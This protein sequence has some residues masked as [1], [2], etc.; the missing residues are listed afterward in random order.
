MRRRRATSVVLAWLAGAAMLTGGVLVYAGHVLSNSDQF[1]T[2]ATA[3]LRDGAMRGVIARTLTSKLLSVEPD[4]VAVRPLVSGVA[5]LV[6]GSAPF[7]AIVEGAIYDVHR[8]VFVRGSDTFTIRLADLG[9]LADAQLRKFAPE[10][11]KRI[12]ESTS[13]VL[14]SVRGGE[15]GRVTDVGRSLN[16]ARAAGMWLLVAALLG[17]ILSI[18]LALKR[19]AA[20][21]RCGLVVLGAGLL[22]AVV[23]TVARALVLAQFTVGDARTAAGV[24][25]GA[26]LADFRFWALLAAGAGALVAAVAWLLGRRSAQS[27]PPEERS[28]TPGPPKRSP[29]SGPPERSPRRAVRAAAALGVTAL[30]I[31]G[32]FVL[33][34]A[35]HGEPRLEHPIVSCN[36]YAELCDRPVNQVVFPATHNSMGSSTE[37]GWFF[38]NQDGGIPEQLSAGSA[39]CLSTRTTGSRRRGEWRRC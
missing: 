36:G 20:L 30:V 6:V 5:H 9:V 22:G 21:R 34:S 17:L 19:M 8:T 24:V 31:A 39:A 25:W 37:A 7:Q 28:P 10:L 2:R 27:P 15:L 38:P 18:G 4:L 32:G 16:A 35:S 26:F 23:Y 11:A 14:S 12:P 3:T 13:V 33:A 1:A 29:T